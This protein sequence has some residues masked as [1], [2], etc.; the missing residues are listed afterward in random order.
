MYEINRVRLSTKKGYD[1]KS[2][3]ITAGTYKYL[4]PV[5]TEFIPSQSMLGRNISRECNQR[6]QARNKKI[7]VKLVLLM[8]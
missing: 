3:L 1:S 6:I 4:L 7:M 8:C 2:Y 5:Y